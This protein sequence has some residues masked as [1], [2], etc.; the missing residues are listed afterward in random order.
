MSQRDSEY[1]RDRM[2]ALKA[3]GLVIG[4]LVALDLL[5][6]E[7]ER[8]GQVFLAETGRTTRLNQRL[9]QLFQR[10]L[11]EREVAVAEEVFSWSNAIRELDPCCSPEPATMQDCVAS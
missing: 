8:G 10:A 11:A 5:R 3:G 6:L 4:R 1:A 9:G 2:H 7:S